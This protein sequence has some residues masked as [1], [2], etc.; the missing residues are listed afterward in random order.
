MRKGMMSSELCSTGEARIYCESDQARLCWTCDDA[1][2]AANFLVGKH[3]RCL[4]C[5]VCSSPTP[6]SAAGRSI[7]RAVSVCNNCCRSKG[8]GS[9]QVG[10]M[11]DEFVED[12]SGARSVIANDGVVDDEIEDE[13][14]EECGEGDDEDEEE[15]EDDENQVVP[16]TTTT[17]S[18]AA[19]AETSVSSG[20]EEERSYGGGTVKRRR[21]SLVDSDDY[22]DDDEGTAAERYRGCGLQEAVVKRQRFESWDC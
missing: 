15:D 10:S 12:E 9:K 2:H 17:T 6:W 13:D 21:S 3:P 5:N 1:V 16:W 18:T 11:E 8:Y 22:D 4:L 19:V 20:G 7:D 14:E